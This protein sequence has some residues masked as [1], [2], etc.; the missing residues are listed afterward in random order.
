MRTTHLPV[1]FPTSMCSAA[2]IFQNLIVAVLQVSALASG[3]RAALSELPGV[4]VRDIGAPEN[5]CGLVTFTVHT[6][7]LSL[8]DDSSQCHEFMD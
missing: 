3:L 1:S 6:P 5:Q 4:V 7:S 2:S 8:T